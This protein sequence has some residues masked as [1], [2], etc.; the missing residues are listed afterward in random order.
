MLCLCPPEF[1]PCK[2]LREMR[3]AEVSWFTFKRR[4]NPRR[5]TLSAHLPHPTRAGYSLCDLTIG[6]NEQ[7]AESATRKC[8]TCVRRL[9]EMRRKRYGVGVSG[10]AETTS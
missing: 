3:S 9:R 5:Q 6:E 4:T 1:R 7:E 10:H 8:Q 2:D